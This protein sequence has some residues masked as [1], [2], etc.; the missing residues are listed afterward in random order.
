MNKKMKDAYKGTNPIFE[1]LA[2]S[3]KEE[4]VEKKG[5]KIEV[6]SAINGISTIFN[7]FFTILLNSKM[8]NLKTE[9]GFQEIKN[10]ILGTN[11]ASSLK[12]YLISLLGSF[13]ALDP[14]Q[15]DAY[16]QNIKFIDETFS[17][18]ENVLQDPKMYES[19]KKDTISK[20]LSDFESDLVS[21]ENQMKKTN[22]KLFGEVVK[23]GLAVKEAKRSGEEANVEDAEFRGKAFNKSKESLDAASSFVGSIDRDKYTPTLKDNTDIQRYQKIAQDLYKKAQDLQMLDT[24]GLLKIVTSTGEI[25][26]GDYSRQQD[27]LINEIIR[28]KKEYQ[29]I[30]DDILKSTGIILPPPVQ[31][32]CP[33]GK[34]YDQS[35]GICISIEAPKKEDSTKIAPVPVVDCTFPISLNKKCNQVGEIQTKL[36]ELLPSVKQYL[37]KRGGADKVYGKGTSSVCN[38]IWAY[39]SG[40]TGQELTADLTKEMYDGIMALT[41]SDIDTKAASTIAAAIKDNKNW[42]MPIKDKIQEREEI[43]GSSVLSFE[44]FYSIIEESYSF[45]KIDEDGEGTTA[46]KIKIS[47]A[48]VK[49][50]LAQGKVLPCTVGKKEEEKKEEVVLPP[51]REEWKG[52]KYV[53][54]STYPISFDE[55][56]LSAWAKEAGIAAISFVIPGSGYLAKAGSAGIKSLAIRGTSL[57]AKAAAKKAAAKTVASWQSRRALVWFSKYKSIPIVGRTSAGLIGGT[58][59]AGALDFLSGRNSFIITVVEGYIERNNLLGMV[60]GLVDTLDGYVSDEDIACI[61][62]VLSVIK[63]SW[64]I[65]NDGKPVSS[66]GEIKKLYQSEEGEDLS[67]DIN[68]ITDKIGDV[69]GFPSIK[70]ST[71]LS[72]LSDIPWGSAL[73]EVKDFVSKLDGNEDAI[74]SNLSKMSDDYIKAHEEGEYEDVTIE[75][76]EEGEKSEEQ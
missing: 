22:P 68:S 76:L 1:S 70:S 55:S 69:E 66:W 28:Q 19:T 62:S 33:P 51:S 6:S 20:L 7:T 59:G 50:S 56:L 4:K 63:G 53:Q 5:E 72:N 14:A 32:V 12:E 11:N 30:K 67:S 10:K 26:R 57:V 49:D 60:G 9:R 23:Q 31:P 58:I 15:R 17:V 44:D 65:S 46:E 64:T 48:C 13:K 41:A 21:R 37:S 71:P 16:D 40:T 43:K 42:E 36:M 45:S 18:V 35:K 29:R 54:T 24:K 38:I 73:A 75:E 61:A 39:I 47:D 3:L 34:K 8:E 52:L 74:K 2:A 27:S 25:K